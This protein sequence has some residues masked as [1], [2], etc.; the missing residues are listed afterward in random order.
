MDKIPISPR[1]GSN[2]TLILIVDDEA[3]IAETLADLVSDLGYTAQVAYNGQQALALA[4]ERW[5]ALVITDLM[6][7]VL[8]GARLI[9]ALHAEA[10]SR[11][12]PSPPIV[13]LTAVGT[14]AING[15]RVEAVLA[16]PFDLNKL[17]QLIHRLIAA[18]PKSN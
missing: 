8:D 4:R 16:K 10:S 3:A 11:N 15:L 13:L 1:V 17:E 18:S 5:P 9:N 7:P 6:M 12:I 14:R 2:L